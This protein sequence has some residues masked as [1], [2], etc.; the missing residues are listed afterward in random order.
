TGL[1]GDPVENFAQQ[2]SAAHKKQT[3]A[4]KHI[5][6][7]RAAAASTQPPVTAPQHAR[8]R[9][10]PPASTP[11]S[12]P[13]PQQPSTMRRRGARRRQAAP[14]ILAPV[15]SRGKQNSK[16]PRNGPPEREETAFQER[17]NVPLPPL[18]EGQVEKL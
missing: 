12:P 7:W 17:M 14:P 2:F 1:F 16:R 4:V 11:P 5:L 15:K 18:E 8:R 13:H 3:E 9:G 10:P 6:P